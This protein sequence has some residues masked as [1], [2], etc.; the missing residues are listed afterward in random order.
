[1]LICVLFTSALI[2]G[3]V[4]HD[5]RDWVR[6]SRGAPTVIALTGLVA[7]ASAVLHARGVGP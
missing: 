3:Q 5:T 2:C 1:M 6:R 7:S 4:L